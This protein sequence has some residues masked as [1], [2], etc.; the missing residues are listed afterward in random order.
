MIEVLIV[1]GFAFFAGVIVC[2]LYHAH[3]AASAA[4]VDTLIGH[5]A[6]WFVGLFH[7]TPTV[8]PAVFPP[9]TTSTPPTPP[10]PPNDITAVR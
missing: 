7:R 6:S 5:F 4:S 9:S 3:H 8:T 10:T 2:D 1:G